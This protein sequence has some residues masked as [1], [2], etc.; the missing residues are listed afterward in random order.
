[1]ALVP[2]RRRR[3]AA[4][5]RVAAGLAAAARDLIHV[6]NTASA[7]T[8]VSPAAALHAARTLAL[9]SIAVGLAWWGALEVERAVRAR[10]ERPV[11]RMRFAFTAAVA[12][13]VALALAVSLVS[14]GRIARGVD[15]QYSAF[16]HLDRTQGGES[17]TG[18]LASGGGNRYDYWRVAARTWAGDP[19]AG[20]GGGNYSQSYY[21]ERH[22]TEAI[23]QPHSLELQTLAELGVIGIALLGAVLAAVVAGIQAQRR[24]AIA[25]PLE[26]GLLVACTGILAAWALHT[27]VDW[28]HLIP[29]VSAVALMVLAIL[30]RAGP[31]APAAQPR[32]RSPRTALLAG[33]CVIAVALAAVSLSRQALADWF[34]SKAQTELARS[35]AQAIT[36]ADRSLRL[37][38]DAPATYY[39]KAAA[40]ARSG[41]APAAEQILGTAIAREPGNFVSY[42]L[43]GDVYTRQGNI[44]AAKR[45]YRAALARNPREPALVVLAR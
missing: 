20:V 19:L 29:G 39:V 14:A 43:L 37:D 15:H 32:G 28:M 6:F 3:V 30:L 45:A 8:G 9:V 25:S 1:V 22:T 13:A 26:R 12:G 24:R 31:P 18:R 10:G 34:R 36:W 42:A 44:A 11:E 7:S 41:D 16:V 27:S 40:V 23:L 33:L 17:S 4:L 21:R 38:P 5:A 35:P 2:G